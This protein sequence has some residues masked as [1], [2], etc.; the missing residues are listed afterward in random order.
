MNP[1]RTH[2][3]RWI[4]G[5]LLA[6]VFAVSTGVSSGVAFAQDSGEG[7][8]MDPEKMKEKIKEINKLMKQAEEGLVRSLSPAGKSRATE[9]AIETLLDQKARESA[10]KSAEELRKLAE[11]GSSEAQEQLQKLLKQSTEQVSKMASEEIRKLLEQAGK[12]SGG[13]GEGI[14]KMLESTRKDGEGVVER[15]EWVLKNAE[16]KQQQKPKDDKQEQPQK[17]ESKQEEPK[18]PKGNE[19]WLA[20]LPPQIRKAYLTK[21]WDGIPPKWRQLIQEWTKKM[22]TELEKDR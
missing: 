2:V 13:A 20:Q 9:D 19:R 15:I 4:G 14:Q 7:G 21:D 10:G 17:P 18:D 6:G 1:T 12:G 5:L 16:R 8:Q 3:A 11:Q 22:S